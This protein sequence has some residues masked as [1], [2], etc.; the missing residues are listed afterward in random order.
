M[1]IL[2]LINY[3]KGIDN[4]FDFEAFKTIYSL[5]YSQHQI[6]KAMYNNLATQAGPII[7]YSSFINILLITNSQQVYKPLYNI[8][9]LFYNI[10]TNIY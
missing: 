2:Y 4:Y 6:K 5:T 1:F 9:V 7:V 10:I 8:R 3:L